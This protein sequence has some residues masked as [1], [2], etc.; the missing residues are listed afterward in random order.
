M[1]CRQGARASVS[2]GRGP[3]RRPERFLDGR[4]IVGRPVSA[5]ERAE[6]ARHGPAVAALME[7]SCCWRA[8]WSGAASG[9][10]VGWSGTTASSS[11]RSP[12]PTGGPSEARE[13]DEDRR[14]AAAQAD[15]THAEGLRRARRARCPSDRAGPGHPPRPQARAPRRRP[16]PASPGSTC[17]GRP[18]ASSRSSGVTKPTVVGMAL[19]PGRRPARDWDWRE[20][21]LLWDLSRMAIG[22][23]RQPLP[24]ATPRIAD[25]H[26]AFSPNG[27]YLAA[28]S[29]VTS[30]LADRTV[31][32]RRG[33]PRPDRFRSRGDR[34]HFMCFDATGCRVA[35]IFNRSRE[36]GHAVEVWEP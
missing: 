32:R 25:N 4:P 33:P 24:V 14:G 1:K 10:P 23:P 35:G 36:G 6:R 20:S 22:R 5:F 27:R 31:R 16:A 11:S 12:A 34:F 3:A 28:L 2:L 19:A 21:V 9:G 13:A 30:N 15:G 7:S 17:G 8:G 18:I 26:L 29:R